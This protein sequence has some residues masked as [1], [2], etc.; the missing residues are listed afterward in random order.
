MITLV[1]DKPVAEEPKVAD[2]STPKVSPEEPV[3][4]ICIII[5]S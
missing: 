3:A 1:A 2:T 5:T 4:I